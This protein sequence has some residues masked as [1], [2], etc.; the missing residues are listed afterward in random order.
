[1]HIMAND[2]LGHHRAMGSPEESHIKGPAEPERLNS[3]WLLEAERTRI[4]ATA[5]LGDIWKQQP[6][7]PPAGPVPQ[8]VTEH[9]GEGMGCAPAHLR[10]QST[11]DHRESSDPG[12]LT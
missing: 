1:M 9:R 5:G 7:V 10:V 8:P 11:C 12:T 2:N 6:P 3:T 4:P